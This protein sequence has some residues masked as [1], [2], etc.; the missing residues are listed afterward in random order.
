MKSG[1]D[2]A[3]TAAGG[4][5]QLAAALGITPQALHE[6]YHRGW[7]PLARATQMRDLYDVPISE[8]VNPAIADAFSA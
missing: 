2:K 8:T 3:I 6:F 5:P 1:I 7:V 4:R